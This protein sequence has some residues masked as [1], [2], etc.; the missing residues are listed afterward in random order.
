MSNTF[1]DFDICHRMV[2]LQ[3][4]HAND[5]G[6]FFLVQKFKIGMY[7]SETVRASVKMYDRHLYMLTFSME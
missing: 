6:L 4:L 3:K 1:V 5:L 7:I 2:L